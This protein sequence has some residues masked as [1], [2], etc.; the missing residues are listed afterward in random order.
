MK[1][2]R[3]LATLIAAS[4]LCFSCDK[5]ME[6]PGF[7]DSENDSAFNADN[8][9]GYFNAIVTVKKTATDTVYF[10]L[11][12]STT[13]Y[14]TNYQDAYTRMERVIGG[15]HISDRP[16]GSFKYTCW[17]EWAE[18]LEEGA[19]STS[20][21][22]AD[23]IDIKDDW[24]TSVEDGFLTIHYDALWGNS[25]KIHN[26]SVA[27]GTNPANPYELVLRHDANGDATDQKG[28]GL[29]CFDINSLPDTEG[30]YKQ[31]TLKW[32]DLEGK[33]CER[34]FKFKTR[35]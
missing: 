2:K 29:V 31:L 30:Q 33:A 3:H 9:E 19:V 17:V 35:E 18:P 28:D 10:Q 22:G 14:P 16:T 12:D 32:N 11:N 24:M 26:F 23:P 6:A 27:T 25:P 21:K 4:A 8:V 7:F 5:A 1:M 20:A 34:Q 15:V 13:V